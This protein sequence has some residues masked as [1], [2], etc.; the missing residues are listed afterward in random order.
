ML[1]TTVH[2]SIFKRGKERRKERKKEERK[3]GRKKERERVRDRNREMETE[4][5]TDRNRERE[6]EREREERERERAR[7]GSH[8]CSPRSGGAEARR[9]PWLFCQTH[10]RKKGRGE[11]EERRDGE[12]R[13]KRVG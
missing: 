2:L 3:E 11:Q 4:K 7:S 8:T 13:K 10:L 12:G 5:Q 1:N 9:Y 6:R